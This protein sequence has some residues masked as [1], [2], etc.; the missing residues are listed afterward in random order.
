MK[1]LKKPISILL[2]GLFLGA[3]L[4]GCGGGGAKV[5]AKS[6]ST[7]LGQELMDLKTAQEQ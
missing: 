2:T 4:I 6:S 5:T 1:S 3:S 7:T